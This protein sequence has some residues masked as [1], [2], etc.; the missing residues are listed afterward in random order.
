MD[1]LDERYDEAAEDGL[2]NELG[3]EDLSDEEM[4]NRVTQSSKN[5]D[6]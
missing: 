6:D 4:Y 1:E 5:T 3:E 2:L